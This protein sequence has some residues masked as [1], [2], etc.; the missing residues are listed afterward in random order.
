MREPALGRHLIVEVFEADSHLLND[1]QGLEQLLLDAARAAN[2]TVVKSVF[3]RF[4]PYGVSGVVVI[5]E[6][7]LTIHTWPEYGYAAID[8]FTC[9][10]KMDLDA[11]VEVIRQGLGGRLLQIEINRGQ[12]VRRLRGDRADCKYA[13]GATTS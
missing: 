9:G 12:G 10:P 5:A 4:S 1:V 7:H 8:I 13:V 6:S 11:A 2:A 3:H